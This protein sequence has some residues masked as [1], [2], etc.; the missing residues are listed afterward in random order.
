MPSRKNVMARM[1]PDLVSN[2][3]Q[4]YILG[5]PTDE[6]SKG[7]LVEIMKLLLADSESRNLANNCRKPYKWSEKQHLLM[8]WGRLILVTE[9]ANLRIQIQQFVNTI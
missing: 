3:G 5:F 9:L 7:T 1:H 6:I 2:N 4:E 8:A